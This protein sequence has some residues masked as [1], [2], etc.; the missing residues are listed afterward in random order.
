VEFRTR[1]TVGSLLNDTFLADEVGPGRTFRPILRDALVIQETESWRTFG[2]IV[3][4]T[5][6]ASWDET[7]GTLRWYNRDASVSVLRCAWG[8]GR[9]VSMDAVGVDALESRG[10]FGVLGGH[11]VLALDPEA[12]GTFWLNVCKALVAHRRESVWAF[13]GCR[14][15]AFAIP[16]HLIIGTLRGLVGAADGPDES[17]AGWTLWGSGVHT[18]IF[19]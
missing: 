8:T 6:A 7:F 2:I 9:G 3:C 1:G 18:V 16:V 13:R 12:W 17:E 11:A 15:D 4:D 5:F 19:H 14:D 10:T